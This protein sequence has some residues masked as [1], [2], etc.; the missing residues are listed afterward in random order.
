MIFRG[1]G[2]HQS[3]DWVF[4]FSFT[5][6][7]D[8]VCCCC[9]FPNWW[10]KFTHQFGDF[11]FFLASTLGEVFFFPKHP[12]YQMVHPNYVPSNVEA[13]TNTPPH[14]M[15]K[16]VTHKTH[17]AFMIHPT[18]LHQLTHP[19]IFTCPIQPCNTHFMIHSTHLQQFTHPLIA[20][21]YVTHKI[22]LFMI[23]PTHLH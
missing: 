23:Q 14:P 19:L 3:W 2:R 9:C 15:H 20:T 22:H 10:M 1:E 5:H 17:R 18:H 16:H 7:M 4:F 12:H 6:Q 21:C 11:L 13:L 8:E